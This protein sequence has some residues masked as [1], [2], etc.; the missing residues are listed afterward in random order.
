MY[1]HVLNLDTIGG[2]E[3]LYAF[4]LQKEL[5][6]KISV[7]HTA[8]SG[9]PPHKKFSAIFAEIGHKPF[10]E[11]YVW[12][13]R[14]PKML[15]SIITLR[16]QIIE[17][18]VK[19]NYWVF[20]NRIEERS[21]PGKAAYY[22][23]GA[24][25]TLSPSKKRRNFLS[26]CSL[27]LANSKAS[28]LMLREKWSIDRSVHVVQNPLRPDLPVAENPR[29]LSCS[30]PLRLGFMGRLVPVKGL[31]VVIHTL[32]E[33]HTQGVRATLCVAGTGPEKQF[34]QKLSKKLGLC[35]CIEW[36]GNV[37]DISCFFDSI[38][39]LL[40]PSVREPLG[41]VAVEA[42]ASAVPVVSAEIDGLAEV[43]DDKKTG[44]TVAPTLEIAQAGD[45]IGRK[46][47]FPDLVVY[48]KEKRVAEPKIVDPKLYAHAIMSVC[49][50]NTY[51]TMSKNCID[52]ARDRIDFGSYCDI[53]RRHMQGS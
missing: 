39:I 42:L 22:E 11:R 50:G 46:E 7:H 16:R 3:T 29:H 36:K 35:S 14:I 38:D 26:S 51:S 33:L 48:P 10:L 23:H 12:K 15:R 20:W 45:L 30:T 13:I 49:E 28:A 24:A 41:L 31:G 9:S 6:K 43:I 37:T 52:S 34:A 4:F 47:G 8:V 19:P 53:L 40:V 44:R 18:L 17:T 27:F 2:V 21:P 32:K 25:W 5:Q 1:I